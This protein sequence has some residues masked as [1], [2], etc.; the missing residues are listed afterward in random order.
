MTGFLAGMG[1]ACA[2]TFFAII[3]GFGVGFIADFLSEQQ[4]YLRFIGGIV[5]I[6]LGTKIFYTNTLR[7]A[8]Q[9]RRQKASKGKLLGDFVSVFFLT[10]SNP[11]TIIVFGAVFA[12]IGVADA[13]GSV[14]FQTAMLVLS[15]F[16]GAT[17]WWLTLA[18]G[19]NLFRHRIRLRSLW[20]I[21]KIAGVIIA[22]LGVVFLVSLMYVKEVP[23]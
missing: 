6:V 4:F 10:L 15:V 17:L 5:L 3:A 8:R 9:A 22:V 13:T 1:A 14:T 2:D 7:Q 20:W 16:V 23:I 11:I 21:N 18:L 12:G 19:V